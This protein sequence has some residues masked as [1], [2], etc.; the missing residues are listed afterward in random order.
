MKKGVL[1]GIAF[2]ILLINLSI[3]NAA[4]CNLDVSLIN[5]DP[6]PAIP[7]DY[8]KVVFQINGISNPECGQVKFELLEKYPI[9]LDPNQSVEYIINSGVYKSDYNSFLL[10]PY[11]IRVDENA[12]QG[13][14]PIEVQY[15]YSSNAGYE[16][17]QFNLHVEDSR[18][19]FEIYVKNY[20]TATQE[21][22]FEILNIADSDIEALTIEIPKQNNI[23][24]KGSKINIVGDLDSNEYTTADFEAI[25]KAGEINLKVSYT[26]STGER[27]TMEKVVYFEPEYFQGRASEQTGTSIWT[28]L[29]ILILVIGA[30]YYYHRRKKKKREEHHKHH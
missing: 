8:V 2:T 15:K 18:A 4:V 22:T 12:L 24:V 17:K 21:I 6:Y 13:D 7:G 23:E 29:I 3:I 27:R 28:K 14:N 20:D 25:P 19:D 16:T 30:V 1:F 5:Q 9:K 11:K 26:D 10:A